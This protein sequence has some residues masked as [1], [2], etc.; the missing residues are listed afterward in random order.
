[1]KLTFP[2]DSKLEG[3]GGLNIVGSGKNLERWSCG[4]SAP[5]AKNLFPLLGDSWLL[6]SSGR[7][8]KRVKAEQQSDREELR[9]QMCDAEGCLN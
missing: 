9:T 6:F 5:T 7:G 8:G 4:F 3:Y 2:V 1:M